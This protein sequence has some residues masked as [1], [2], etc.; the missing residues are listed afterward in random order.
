MVLHLSPM[1]YNPKFVTSFLSKK[2]DSLNKD[3]DDEELIGAKNSDTKTKTVIDVK[4]RKVRFSELIGILEVPSCCSFDESV[5]KSTWYNRY[6]LTSFRQERL[7]F[8][9]RLDAGE[10]LDTTGVERCTRQGISKTYRNRMSALKAVLR[11]QDRHDEYRI[12]E[13]YADASVRAKMVANT[14]GMLVERDA[15]L[16]LQTRRRT[17]RRKS[18]G[19]LRNNALKQRQAR[20]NFK[21]CRDDLGLS[22]RRDGKS[23]SREELRQALFTVRRVHI[24]SLIR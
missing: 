24:T 1:D 13:L 23:P 15:K 7:D 2:Y 5:R 8:I 9:E 21:P 10:D 19:F 11:N 18:D 6:D 14:R 12:A 16:Y 20:S 4:E 3:D 22:P 17:P